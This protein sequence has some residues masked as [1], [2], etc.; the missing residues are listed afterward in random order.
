MD[1]GYFAG[2]K[3]V[4]SCSGLSQCLCHSSDLISSPFKGWAAIL[5]WKLSSFTT[6]HSVLV[7]RKVLSVL[8]LSMFHAS[9]SFLREFQFCSCT[10]SEC[11][12]QQNSSPFMRV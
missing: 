1:L 3:E 6:C 9:V 8:P 2:A 11:N 7:G 12:V 4:C 10:V 5:V